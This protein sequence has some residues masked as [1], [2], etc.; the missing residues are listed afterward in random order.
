M[1]K[2]FFCYRDPRPSWHK[3]WVASFLLIISL[4]KEC[5]TGCLPALSISL[6]IWKH[7]HKDIFHA[8][9]T[10]SSPYTL[11]SIFSI[12]LE[13]LSLMASK[14]R[15]VTYFICM[16]ILIPSL[17]IWVVYSVCLLPTVIWFG[18][19]P[20]YTFKHIEC[21]YL[22]LVTCMGFWLCELDLVC[23]LSYSG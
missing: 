2:L 14:D 13:I 9:E 15:R 19:G 5:F 20:Y 1:S 23:A 10:A 22:S 7:F 17:V 8:L 18:M 3:W 21:F 11:L 16:M 6:L 12:P 4:L